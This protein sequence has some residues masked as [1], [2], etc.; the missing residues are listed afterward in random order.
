MSKILERIA[1]FGVGHQRPL[2]VILKLHRAEK[3]RLRVDRAI[4]IRDRTQ[5][6][7]G[8]FLLGIDGPS[9]PS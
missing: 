9:L 8:K 4:A 5:Q 3:E 6:H 2:L 1:Q 7:P